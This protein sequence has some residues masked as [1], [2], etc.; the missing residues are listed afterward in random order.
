MLVGLGLIILMGF[1]FGLYVLHGGSLEV[2]LKAAPIELGIILGAGLGATII[3]N[4]VRTLKGLALGFKRVVTGSTVGSGDYL[5]AI[6]LVAGLMKTLQKKGARALENDIENPTSSQI[7][8]AYPSVLRDAQL[9]SL[10]TSTLRLLII[11]SNNAK[12]HDVEH[13]ME[14]AIGA[15]HKERLRPVVALEKLASGLPALG[16][17]ACILGIVKTMASIDSPPSVLGALIASA[18]VGTFLGVFLAY[19]LVEP[20]SIRLKRIVNQ[21]MELF[22]VVQQIIVGTIAGHSQPLII[23]AARAS[24]EPSLQPSFEDVFDGLLK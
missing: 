3:G 21:E 24:I 2:I 16:I 6:F 11:S 13:V 4:D 17:V 22:H 10:I 14:T 7:F 1:V 5:D 9:L 23:E 8:V 19:G 12:W 20:L 18:L 15:V